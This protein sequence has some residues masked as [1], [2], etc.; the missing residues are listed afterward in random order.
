MGC[1]TAPGHLSNPGLDSL[2]PGAGLGPEPW[3]RLTL[4]TEP[5]LFPGP[6]LGPLCAF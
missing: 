2:K 6:A 4:G 3:E 1:C 5:R